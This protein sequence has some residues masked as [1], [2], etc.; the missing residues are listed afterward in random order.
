MSVEEARSESRRCKLV[1]ALSFLALVMFVGALLGIGIDQH[2]S[3]IVGIAF[4]GVF[5]LFSLRQTWRLH[6][7]CRALLEKSD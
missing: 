1:P 3:T 5:W 4:G 2:G 7:C 6:A